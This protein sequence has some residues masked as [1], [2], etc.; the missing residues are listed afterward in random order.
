LISTCKQLHTEL[1]DYIYERN[2]LCFQ[3]IDKSFFRGEK[4]KTAGKNSM[5]NPPLLSPLPLNAARRVRCLELDISLMMFLQYCDLLPDIREGFRQLVQLISED[6]K[7]ISL[8]SVSVSIRAD[9]LFHSPSRVQEIAGGRFGRIGFA[10]IEPLAGLYGLDKVEI[11]GYVQPELKNKLI[12][13]MTRKE[14]EEIPTS[15]TIDR[16]RRRKRIRLEDFDT[17]ELDW[18]TVKQS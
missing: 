2:A 10:A 15:N 5:G 8:K 13:V 18:T 1:E 17:L 14:R 4:I 11:K 16:R 7:P 12:Y 3:I 9:R 6:G